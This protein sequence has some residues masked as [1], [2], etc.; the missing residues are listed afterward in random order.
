VSPPPPDPFLAALAEHWADVLGRADDTTRARLDGVLARAGDAPPAATRAELVGLVLGLG[1]SR[2]H[3]VLLALEPDRSWTRGEAAVLDGLDI[4]VERLR[5]IVGA[6][7]GDLPPAGPL[8]AADL[9]D[10]DA[11]VRSRLLELPAVTPQELLG[12]G[13]D[14]GLPGLIRLPLAGTVR[15]PA[16]QFD[17]SGAPRRVVLRVNEL[18]RAEAD[19]WGASCW[20]VDRH[21]RLDVAPRDLL[22]RDEALLVRAARALAED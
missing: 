8:A 6:M 16:F 7:P 5:A 11:Q 3:P 13:L 17:G 15:L 18:L 19:P 2:D 21:A 20:W 9:D 1:L 22:D 4:S 14:P 12:A 10:F